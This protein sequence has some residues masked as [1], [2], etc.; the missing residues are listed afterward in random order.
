MIPYIISVP[1]YYNGSAGIRLL[2]KLCHDL[3][4]SG[5][6]AYVTAKVTNKKWNTPTLTGG[7]FEYLASTG[8]NVLYPEIIRGNP[9]FA[10][11]I[12]R[13]LQQYIGF[14]G[15]DTVY[16]KNVTIFV[17]SKIFLRPGWP[18][19][20]ILMQSVIEPEL[21]NMKGVG[22]RKFATYYF[23]KKDIDNNIKRGIKETEIV[24]IIQRLPFCKPETREEVADLLKKSKILYCYDDLTAMIDEARL[25][26]CPVVIY[27]NRYNRAFY[28]KNIG[29]DGGLAMGDSPNEIAYAIA[30][31]KNF[32]EKYK[33]IWEDYPKQLKHFIEVTQK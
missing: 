1:D 19:E 32:R 15:G 5:C 16:D 23:G 31:I 20:N 30:T 10:K 4:S 6:E 2:H 21:F 9:L 25:C 24:R 26:G 22:P 14:M 12:I 27:S 11:R 8:A 3:N 18:K 33:K 17:Y 28:R 29:G 13:Y 7:Q